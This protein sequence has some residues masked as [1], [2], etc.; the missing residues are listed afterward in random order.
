MIDSSIL[1]GKKAAFFT[2][3]CKL[4]FAET[5]SVAQELMRYGV[6]KAQKGEVA[7]ICIVNTCS[8]TEVAD[9][10]CRQ[11]IH[12]LVKQ[13][14]GAFVVVTGCYAQLKPQEIIDTEGVDLV[15]GSE[16]KAHIIPMILEGMTQQTLPPPSLQG[17]SSISAH[18][19]PLAR[20]GQTNE[21]SNH[22]LPAEREGGGSGPVFFPACSRG[23]RT[24]YFLKV[25]D[26]C[27][28]YCTYCTIPI[29]RGRSR[30]G[31]IASMVAQAKQVA[32]EGGKEIV[33]TGVNIGDFG[34][35]TGETFFDLVKA[36]DQV[37]G[38]ERYRISSIEPNLLTDEII[39]FC[40]DSKRFMP[41]FHIPLQSGCDEVLRLMHRKYDTALFAHKIEKIRSVMPDAFIGVDVI[42]GTRGETQEY[43]DKAYEFMQ[44][45]DVSQYHVFSYSE[46]PGTKALEIPHVVTPQEKHERSQR[47]LALSAQKTHDFYARFI[48]TT[49]HVLLEHASPRKPFM[50]GFTDNYIRVEVPNMPEQDNQIMQVKLSGFNKEGDALCGEIVSA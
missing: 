7:D 9:H 30:N 48:G 26:G 37:E 6:K 1:Q 12:R 10:K 39:E 3:G 45:V 44:S 36:L 5:G 29:A 31:S 49:R 11:A 46:R 22:S 20:S 25:Q 35:S 34:R 33:I 32:Q 38:I 41:H 13:H 8:V 14:P 19:E 23:D 15:L 42:V 43:F 28:Y 40:A 2:L 18:E 24:R 4:N 47:V 21:P 17:G 50:N 16:Q 27:N